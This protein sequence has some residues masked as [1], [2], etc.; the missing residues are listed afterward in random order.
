M[1]LT[2]CGIRLL[3]E[4]CNARSNEPRQNKK[5]CKEHRLRDLAV[6]DSNGQLGKRPDHGLEDR[7]P[8][9]GT[10]KPLNVPLRM[11]HHAQYVS[12]CIND[13]GDITRR[14]VRIGRRGRHAG[15]VD[16][17][18]NNL[19]VGLQGIQFLIAGVIVPLTVRNR[20]PQQRTLIQTMRERRAGRF[21]AQI[22]VVADKSQG[23]VAHQRTRKQP[24]LTKNLEPV[25][26]PHHQAAVRSKLDDIPHYGRKTRNC[27]GSEV[28]AV[29]KPSG[30]NDYVRIADTLFLVPDKSRLLTKN[31]LD[32]VKRVVV[33]IGPWKYDY[34]ELYRHT[35]TCCWIPETTGIR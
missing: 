13:P 20:N 35:G 9:R 28:I 8:I 10:Q 32:R 3:N 34:P 24:R 5:E 12:V 1:L 33:A 23:R 2:T 7:K 11:R 26:D 15:L 19:I 14:T 18:K 31:V 22:H 29:G 30:Y 21:Y 27:T 6:S 4:R 17:A 25:A 16:V